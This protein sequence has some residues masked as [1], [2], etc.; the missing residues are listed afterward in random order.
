MDGANRY[1]PLADSPGDTLHRAMPRV[2]HGE[3]ARH[4]GLEW[5]WWTLQWPSLQGKIAT[6]QDIPTV[7]A[8]EDMAKP[9]RMRFCADQDEDGRSGYFLALATVHIF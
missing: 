7:V 9:F 3:H 5:Q 4:T 2:A 8:L 1:R 6:R